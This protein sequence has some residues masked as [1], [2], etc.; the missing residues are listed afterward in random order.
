MTS[1]ADTTNNVVASSTAQH[2]IMQSMSYSTVPAG[3]EALDTHHTKTQDKI[4]AAPQ[5]ATGEHISRGQH[6]SPGLCRPVQGHWA[7]HQ[8]R[9][10]ALSPNRP[11][12]NFWGLEQCCLQE[13]HGIAH[14]FLHL[15]KSLLKQP[16]EASVAVDQG[17]CER[18]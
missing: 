12:C 16:F 10:L 18:T 15:D 6:G 3:R 7:K 2:Q 4:Q 14:V 8:V 1:H 5:W 13:L 17:L 9:R 11:P